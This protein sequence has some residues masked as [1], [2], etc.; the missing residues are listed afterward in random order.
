MNKSLLQSLFLL[1]ILI[2]LIA[3]LIAI[4]SPYIAT[5]FWS[6]VLYILCS[7]PYK[8][9]VN[10]L[11]PNSKTFNAKKKVLAA[12]FAIVTVVLISVILI[13]FAFLV[14]RQFIELAQ[15]IIELL[16][17]S[18]E[19]SYFE[20][21]FSNIFESIFKF[22]NKV[23]DLRSFDIKA[24]I[25]DVI[26]KYSNTILRLGKDFVQSAGSFVISLVFTSFSLYFFYVDGNYL[27]EIFAS[28]VPI[29]N[30]SM[31][32]LLKKFSETVTQII[33]SLV[34]VALY[35]G[36]AAFIIYSIFRVK[37]AFLLAVLTFFAA[38]IPLLGSGSIWF[39]ISVFIFIGDSKIKGLIFFIIAGTVISLMDN[40]L[41]PLLLK[42]TIKIHP[43]LIFFSLLGGVKLL[44][45]KGLIL[46]PMTI[47]I[48][49]T[50]LDM[51]LNAENIKSFKLIETK[52]NKP[53]N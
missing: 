34:L 33:S 32:R 7:P 31:K 10:R 48:F 30:K 19:N 53:E 47:I 45:L 11:D 4:F 17:S 38:F 49:F 15:L 6:V 24:T 18:A 14:I 27:L 22:T 25:I 2:A 3:L 28:S 41:R 46:G 39:P 51:V 40:V 20:D 12:F 52:N 37:G 44:G 35:Q 43:L 23:V 5:L 36:V 9:I 1:V 42:D 26:S 16:T 29:E 13:G 21:F 50:V 8:A